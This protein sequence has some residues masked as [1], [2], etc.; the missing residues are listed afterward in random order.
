[1]NCRQTRWRC[2]RSILVLLMFLGIV[3]SNACGTSAPTRYYLLSAIPSDDMS[4]D[5]GSEPRIGVGPI[6]FVDY[7]HRQQ[8]VSR[9]GPNELIVASLDQWAEPLK[10]NFSRVLGENLS[11]LLDTD[12]VFSFPW[13]FSSGVDYQ[14]VISVSRFEAGEDGEFVL[15]ASWDIRQDKQSRAF[16]KTTLSVSVDSQDY[17]THAA[18]ASQVVAQLSRQIAEEIKTVSSQQR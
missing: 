15:Q 6:E 2:S 4:A 17:A 13:K 12:A 9:Q 10:K 14:V 3:L 18:A 7:L 1:M 16:R 11:K 8:I 5:R